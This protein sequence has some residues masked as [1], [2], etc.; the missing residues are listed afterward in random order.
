MS[1]RTAKGFTLVELL[2]ALAVAGV[3]LGLG[4]PSFVG[5]IRNAQLNAPWAELRSALFLARSEA[6]KGSH[7]V[8]VCARASDTTCGADWDA[9]WLVYVEDPAAAAGAVGAGTILRVAD[10]VGDGIDLKS[11][12]SY[13]RAAS[14]VAARGFIRYLATGE[15]DWT[16]GTFTVCDERGAEE[17]LA[18]NVALTGDIR[19]ARASGEVVLDA[20]GREVSCP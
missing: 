2:V 8:S 4:V 7:V 14:G 11:A 9:G 20:F 13:N 19:T 12:G 1:N 18:L 3:L 10:P 15:A 17:A 6:V 5:A 16:N